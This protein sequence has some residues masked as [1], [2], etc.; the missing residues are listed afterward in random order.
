MLQ[1]AMIQQKIMQLED[2]SYSLTLTLTLTL[3]LIMQL[4]DRSYSEEGRRRA[5]TE[6][7]RRKTESQKQ[8]AVKLKDVFQSKRAS[9]GRSTVTT[10]GVDVL[11]NNANSS[12]RSPQRGGNPY[13]SYNF[14]RHVPAA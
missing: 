12:A 5:R 7:T 11:G 6:E 9:T 10:G 8:L 3:T 1:I 2:R 13:L 14:T 4:E